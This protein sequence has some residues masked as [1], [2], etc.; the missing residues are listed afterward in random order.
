MA[1]NSRMSQLAGKD[2]LYT[3]NWKLFTGW[4]YMIGNA[5]TSKNKAAEI[6]TIFRVGKIFSSYSILWLCVIMCQ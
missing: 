2:D 1:E 5:E 4:D 3:F 6:S